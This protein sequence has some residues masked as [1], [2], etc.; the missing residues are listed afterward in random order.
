MKSKLFAV[1]LLLLMCLLVPPPKATSNAQHPTKL[2]DVKK[3]EDQLKE[4][5]R[6]P[7]SVKV[8]VSGKKESS[9]NI[10][11]AVEGM[12]PS[13]E[14]GQEGKLISTKKSLDIDL[15]NVDVPDEYI[16]EKISASFLAENQI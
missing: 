12:T 9:A 2:S 14:V 13:T 8:R 10:K 4:L 1:S 6:H 15:K 7:G 11:V 16:N 5:E 3:L